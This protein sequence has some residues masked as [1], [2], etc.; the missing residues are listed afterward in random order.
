MIYEKLDLYGKLLSEIDKWVY[1]G[2]CVVGIVFESQLCKLQSYVIKL[3]WLAKSIRGSF[4]FKY[5]LIKY[6]IRGINLECLS[7]CTRVC[8]MRVQDVHCTMFDMRYKCINVL[9]R[10]Q[11]NFGVSINS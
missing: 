6:A 9:H 7:M 2:E 8:V 5:N 4:T 11:L 10:R 1:Y 3:E